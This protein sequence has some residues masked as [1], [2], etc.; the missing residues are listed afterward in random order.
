MYCFADDEGAAA[1]APGD[2]LRTAGGVGQHVAPPWP[3]AA[4][5]RDAERRQG[6]GERP[7][8]ERDSLHRRRHGNVHSHCGWH[9]QGR[10]GSQAPLRAI[11]VHGTLQNLLRQQTGHT[12]YT[13]VITYHVL[14]EISTAGCGTEIIWR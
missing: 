12:M 4:G 5:F 10:R 9:V 13:K 8:Q 3:R 11:P 6:R 14:L 7:R 1:G 2:S